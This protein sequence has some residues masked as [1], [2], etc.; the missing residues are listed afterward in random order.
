MTMR[1]I[2]LFGFATLAF[3]GCGSATKYQAAASGVPV[4]RLLNIPFSPAP[5]EASLTTV[6]VCGG[7]GSWKREALWD[8]YVVRLKNSGA[9]PVMLTGVELEDFSGAVRL[10][11]AEPWKLESESVALAKEFKRTGVTFAKEALPAG[12][13]AG[14]AAEYSA[15]VGWARRIVQTVFYDGEGVGPRGFEGPAPAS[16]GFST[17]AGYALV[18]VAIAERV[19]ANRENR[20]DIEAEFRL[21]RLALPVR[22]APGQARAGCFFF[23]MGPNPRTLKLFWRRG[24]ESGAVELPLDFLRGLHVPPAAAER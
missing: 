19:L 18:P 2:R 17:A 22:L 16:V 14:A 20:A 24:A 21:R 1:A 23:P 8:E 13:V 15:Y 4:A 5:V 9:E 11:G 3:C 12:L 6:I 7:P 10:A